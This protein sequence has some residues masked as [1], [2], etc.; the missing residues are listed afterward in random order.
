MKADAAA[1]SWED[2]ARWRITVTEDAL[3]GFIPYGTGNGHLGVRVGL[4]GLDW[5]GD[6]QPLLCEPG[7]DFWGRLNAKLLITLARYAYDGGD[8]LILPAWNQARLAIGG[9][10]YAASA[11]RHR[12]SHTL[13]LR[14]G[15]VSLEDRWEYRPGCSATLRLSLVVPRSHT[16]ASWYEL[17]LSDLSEPAALRI[18]LNAAQVAD[19]FVK[20]GFSGGDREV[21]GAYATRH[22]GRTL[23]QGLRWEGQGWKET[24]REF[25]ADHAWISLAATG[26]AAELSVIHSLHGGTESAAP[27]QAVRD[28]W[29]SLDPE[30]RKCARSENRRRWKKLWARGLDFRHPTQRWE[31]LVFVNQF[32]LLTS[33]DERGCFPLGPLGLSR[34]GWNGS[35]MWDANL[36]IFRAVLPLW[37]ELARS[38]VAFN[39]AILPAARANAKSQG[40]RGAFYPWKA[41]DDGSD[42]T[43]EGY[44]REIHNNAWVAL[45]AWEASD[46]GRDRAFLEETTWPILSGVADFFVSRAERDA[47]GRWHIRDVIPPDESVHE[48]PQGRGLCDDNALTNAAARAVL[49]RASEAAGLL[50][51]PAPAQWAEVAAGMVIPPPAAD[52]VTPEYDGYSGHAIKQADTILIFYPLDTAAAPETV[53]KNVDYYRGRLPGGVPLMTQQIEA[54]L[55]MRHR[56]RERG[57]AHLFTEYERYVRG[58][59]LIP[60]E[61][62]DNANSIMLTGIGGLLQA[63]VFGWYGASLDH[64]Q[65]VPR[66]G[67]TWS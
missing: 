31:R 53:L 59:H 19:R 46:G 18:G 25:R 6:R 63:L 3:T 48:V 44:R 51:K 7:G 55:Y 36:W 27:E 60:F 28:D 38:I 32:H 39:R 56:D 4:L 67:A 34:P 20:L 16:G 62:P 1:I 49:R 2:D 66:I 13:D 61:T 33:L 24:G 45:G 26:S 9:V 58:P 40:L 11:G 42:A 64:L 22:Q 57:L 14:G 65:D 54:I 52:G 37:P 29:H 10:E 43:P 41:A 8:Q 23:V 17:S 50:A 5:N 35:Q 12:L 15:E 21:L 47:A 30:G